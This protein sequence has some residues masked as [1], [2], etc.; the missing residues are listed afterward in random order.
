ME[1]TTNTSSIAYFLNI[2]VLGYFCIHKNALNDEKEYKQPCR[3][4]YIMTRMQSF[5]L[6]AAI[7]GCYLQCM[8]HGN[9][10]FV[11]NRTMLSTTAEVESL[12]IVL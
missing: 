5:I 12:L 6:L 7:F 9:M 8:K 2:C 4:E 10:S 11:S 1:A 3:I